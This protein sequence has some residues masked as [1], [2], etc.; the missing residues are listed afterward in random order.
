MTIED[1]PPAAVDL[2]NLQAEIAEEVRHRRAT[3]DFPPGLERELDAMFA[4]YAP[5]GASDDFDD[6][7]AAA[8]TQSFI[9]ADVPTASRR[10]PLA[11]VK[12]A[13]RKVMAWYV[14]FVAQQVTAFAGSITRAVSLLG[15][16][17][18]VLETV[19]L[20]A[21]DQTLAEVR[22]RRADADLTPW[23]DVVVA[24][25]AGVSGRVLHT[26]CGAG[27]LLRALVEAGLE[28][29]GVE[30]DEALTV[31]ASRSGLDVR[32]DTAIAHLRKLPDDTLGGVVLSGCVDAL[33]VGEVL[34]IAARAAAVLVP[35]GVVVVLSAGPVAWARDRDPVIVDLTPGRP[36]HAETWRHV[37]TTRGLTVERIAPLASATPPEPLAPVPDSTPGADVLN[38]NIDR[39]NRVL[40]ADDA[41]AVVARK[42]R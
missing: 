8:E 35:G 15:H 3:G 11:F 1:V 5:A 14:R 21:D 40:F 39:L 10:P 6:V 7:L 42:P 4:K 33:P 30:P 38:A 13:L 22:D 37:L 32:A 41:F 20:I 19:T 17:V 9:H 2:S 24:A 36:L 25:L 23:A 29:Y 26:E 16:R 27:G 31:D 18:D 28:G 12:R 34:A